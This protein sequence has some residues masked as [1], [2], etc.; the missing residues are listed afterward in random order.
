LIGFGILERSGSQAGPATV[1][2]VESGRRRGI[3]VPILRH[4]LEYASVKTVHAGSEIA[5]YLVRLGFY[6]SGTGPGRRS[7]YARAD[8]PFGVSTSGNGKHDRRTAA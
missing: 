4:L 5:P 8:R 1:T 2:L 3:G 6:R 7:V